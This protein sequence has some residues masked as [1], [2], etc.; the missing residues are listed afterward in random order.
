MLIGVDAML[1]DYF[2]KNT[3]T[4]KPLIDIGTSRLRYKEG[5]LVQ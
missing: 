2:Q 5:L 4:G 3:E 1:K